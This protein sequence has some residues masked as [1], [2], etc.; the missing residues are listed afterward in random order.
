MVS[1]SVPAGL[2]PEFCQSPLC[3]AHLDTHRGLWGPESS[4][5]RGM[6]AE[7]G[8]LKTHLGAWV[9][10]NPQLLLARSPPS[11]MFSPH[12]LPPSGITHPGV[13]QRSSPWECQLPGNS[14]RAPRG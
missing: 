2:L 6:E 14:Y 13:R 10:P 5:L 4:R 11:R 9:G 1:P 12:F 7:P 3:S 8:S